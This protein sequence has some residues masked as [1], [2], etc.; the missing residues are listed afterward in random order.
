MTICYWSCNRN[1]DSSGLT[2]TVQSCDNRKYDVKSATEKRSGNRDTSI[3]TAY[4]DSM[5]K[6]IS[7]V[8][9]DYKRPGLS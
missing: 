3:K 5:Y 6:H 7:Q 9:G 2:R 1:K 4:R 8:S